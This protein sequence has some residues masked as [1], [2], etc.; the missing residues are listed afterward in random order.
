MLLLGLNKHIKF[1]FTRIYILTN[2]TLLVPEV[3][4]LCVKIYQLEIWCY[5]YKKPWSFL[6][7]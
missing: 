7:L 1:S 2:V 5:V 6:F 4:I 3:K